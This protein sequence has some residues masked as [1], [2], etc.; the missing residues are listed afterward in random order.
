MKATSFTVWFRAALAA[1]P[2][3]LLL[4]SPLVGAEERQPAGEAPRIQREQG[5][6]SE[7]VSP[8][9]PAGIPNG[10]GVPELRRQ[11]TPDPAREQ[12]LIGQV[13]EL[14]ER[15][16]YV[17]APSGAV[18]PFDVSALSFSKQPEEGQEVRVTYQVEDETDN[19]AVGLEGAVKPEA[20]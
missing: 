8:T 12:K 11:V 14:K 4:A 9:S 2:L 6:V 17:E 1:G 7:V 5:S 20:Q 13:L 10:I 3:A 19:V 15:T 16:L 18:V